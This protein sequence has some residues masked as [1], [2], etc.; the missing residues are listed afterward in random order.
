MEQ[1][2][3]SASVRGSR[4]EGSSFAGKKIEPDTNRTVIIRSV[5]NYARIRRV[6]GPFL[7]A[8]WLSAGSDALGTLQSSVSAK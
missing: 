3:A 1:I 5:G 6:W 2:N 4:R 7:H 8:L